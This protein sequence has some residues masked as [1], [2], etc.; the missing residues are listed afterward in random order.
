MNRSLLVDELDRRP[1]LAGRPPGR[2]GLA[3]G[4]FWIGLEFIVLGCFEPKNVF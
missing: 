3:L 2:G 4:L 1:D